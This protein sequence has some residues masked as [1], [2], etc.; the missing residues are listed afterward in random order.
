MSI[1][2][3]GLFER[4][5]A[6]TDRAAI[7]V[8]PPRRLFAIDGVGTP[9]AAGFGYA[10]ASLRTVAETLRRTLR[11]RKVDTP[12]AVIECAWWT[13]PELSF[14]E[15]ADAFEDRSTW[16][17]QQMIEIPGPAAD[18]EVAAAID[19]TR[20]GAGR[21]SPLIHVVEITEGRAAQIL[22]VGRLDEEPA[23]V[24]KLWGMVREAGLQPRGH[25]HELLLVDPPQTRD[26]RVRSI[27]RLPVEPQTA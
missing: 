11:R 17:W 23:A 4:R 2:P 8:V 12:R 7:I 14:A 27:L 22:H 13:H 3:S 6:A 9:S 15:F 25:L 19:E 10:A 5:H 18:K 20:R 24:R 16:H 21:A 1:E 26:G